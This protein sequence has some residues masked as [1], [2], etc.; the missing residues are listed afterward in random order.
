MEIS[1]DWGFQR[2]NQELYNKL[3]DSLL[4]ICNDNPE[5][6]KSI[7][8][9][10]GYCMTGETKE[11]KFFIFLGCTGSNGKSTMAEL[12]NISLSIYSI[13]LDKR[14]FNLNYTKKKVS[15]HTF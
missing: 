4:K 10:L 15:K 3:K 5:T 9:W 13:K 8:S 1:N 7:L 14:T 2:L 11:Q 6:L 12:F